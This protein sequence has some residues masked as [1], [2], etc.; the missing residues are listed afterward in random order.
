MRERPTNMRRVGVVAAVAALAGGACGVG[1]QGGPPNASSAA[2]TNATSGTSATT[3]L[4]AT[5]TG[6]TSPGAQATTVE[7]PATT[8]ARRRLP[9][10]TV[11]RRPTTGGAPVES[12]PPIEVGEPCP[13]SDAAAGSAGA[14]MAESSRLE[15]MLA[16]V[17][18]YGGEHPDVF[19]SYGLI[20]H[21]GGDASVFIALTSNLDL[22]RA[23]LEATVEY[24]DELIVCQVAVSEKV[25]AALEATLADEL[26]GRLWS[27][28]PE[29]GTLAVGLA[30]DQQALAA[31]LL[32]RYGDA[33][34]LTVGA[35][36]YPIDDATSICPPPPHINRLPGLEITIVPPVGPLNAADT[37]PPRL[38][39][40]LTNRSD[41]PIEFASGI[42]TGTILDAQGNVVSA[43]TVFIDDVGIA[44]DLDPG[45]S[46]KLPLVT[47]TASCDPQLGYQLPPGN[48]QLIAEVQQSNGA[49]TTLH[50]EP[51]P[52]VIGG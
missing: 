49:V 4:D 36:A 12:L 27:I 13:H 18:A 41:A 44:V 32:A 9:V 28:G 8:S 26:Q 21:D 25:A 45:E 14:M 40:T 10:T 3:V 37:T 1:A 23:A 17:L 7:A 20:W 11:F 43:G 50:S 52:I 47:S 35:L 19:G 30:P 46:M 34:S 51:L 33:I 38:K 31:E 15:P 24:P 42:A 2:P 48:Y 6:T 22:H 39:V 16:Q 5:T 29:M